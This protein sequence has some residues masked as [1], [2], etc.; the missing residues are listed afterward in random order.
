M[1]AGWTS[2]L[3]RTNAVMACLFVPGLVYATVRWGAIGAA[4]TWTAVNV[5]YLAIV[6]RLMHRRLLPGEE[7]RWFLEDVG[8][9][10]AAALCAA[11]IARNLL[12]EPATRME[13]FP[14]LLVGCTLALVA[15]ALV[16]PS[17]RRRL[18]ATLG[19]LHA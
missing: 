6:I 17:T 9:P 18:V 7:R 10:L 11:F 3:L 5:A 4:L 14:S 13:A 8:A 12:P 1:A 15:A 2:L 19:G 16:A